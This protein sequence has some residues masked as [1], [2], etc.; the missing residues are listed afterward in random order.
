MP[1][2][3]RFDGPHTAPGRR[4]AWWYVNN[5]ETGDQL[6]TVAWFGRWRKFA[7]RVGAYSLVLEQDCLRDIADFCAEKTKEHRRQKEKESR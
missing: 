2:W 4:T 3:I 5:V 6:G 1:K 7:F